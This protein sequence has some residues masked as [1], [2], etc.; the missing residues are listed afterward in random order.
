MSV[1]KST[2]SMSTSKKPVDVKGSV[3]NEIQ[4]KLFGQR[5]EDIT[6]LEINKLFDGPLT[7][8]T[9]LLIF[10][11]LEKRILPVDL[12]IL[13]IIPR[14]KSRD[15]LIPIA[16]C[17]R[18]SAD[19][20]MYVKVPNL[21]TMHIL[22]YIYV[23]LSS[24][25]SSLDSN[26]LDIIALMFVIKGSLSSNPIY[27]KNAGKINPTPLA[28][29]PP[30]SQSVL[31]WINERGYPTILNKIKMK[32]DISKVID[33]DSLTTLSILLDSTSLIGRPYESKDIFLAIK[34]FSFDIMPRIV[35]PTTLKFMD[36]R[37]LDECVTD[38]NYVA[39]QDLMNRGQSPSYLLINKILT[40]MKSYKALSHI[41]PFQELEKMLIL[42]VS[43][44]TQLDK[45]QLALISFMGQDVLESVKKE[46]DQ[47][48]W[49]KIC[50]GPDTPI[51]PE[52]LRRLALSLNIDH[53]IGKKSIC[54]SI[55]NLSNADKELLK[56]AAK[57]RQQVRISSDLSSMNE[58]LNDKVPVLTCRNR[59]LLAKD[60]F[61]YNDLDLAYYRD[62]EDITWCFSSD[63]FENLKETGINPYDFS[64]LPDSFKLQL[65]YQI[66][67]LKRLGINADQGEVG[68]YN[69]KIP[70]TFSESIDSLSIKDTVSES[71]SEKYILLF[72][73]LANK[74]NIS[75][76]TVKNLTKTRM[77]DA[78]NSIGYDVDLQSLTTPHALITTSRI[79]A[80]LNKTDPNL[81][82][83]FFSSI[84]IP[85]L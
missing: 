76:D 84:N 81:V 85:T 50:K 11:S 61:E 83:T 41:L 56:E 23:L 7:P 45:D 47:P 62:S 18:F 77:I 38:L 80:F 14:A 73:Q 49:R 57:K 20:N 65:D 72:T 15:Y 32:S 46:Y 59:S 13:Q 5:K 34:A 51:V 17:L 67:A 48:Y 4:K 8:E 40:L 3:Y 74:N 29:S 25:K 68:I 79:I 78:L 43:M 63:T 28:S 54:D 44:G 35:A 53:T 52:S 22:G 70:Q 58:F 19:P 39:Y 36:F 33:N 42:S 82:S 66:S 6:P 75:S 27:D 30:S 16:L 26:I 9:N 12:T 37:S 2:T 21:G 24:N 10:K 1:S 64:P 55:S 31:D 71:D 60:P 69:S